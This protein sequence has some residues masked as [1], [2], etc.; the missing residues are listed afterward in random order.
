MTRQ[1]VTSEKD[2]YDRDGSNSVSYE[3]QLR[4]NQDGNEEDGAQ[5]DDGQENDE[6]ENGQEDD[7]EEAHGEKQGYVRRADHVRGVAGIRPATPLSFY[8]GPFPRL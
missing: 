4:P 2:Y 8:V 6:E 7:E 3:H 5:K 1:E